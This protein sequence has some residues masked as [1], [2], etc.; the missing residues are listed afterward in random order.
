MLDML[1]MTRPKTAL[2]E[3][4]AN[5]GAPAAETDGKGQMKML[6]LGSLSLLFSLTCGCRGEEIRHC[7]ASSSCLKYSD[8]G[9]V[10]A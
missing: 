2:A 8:P 1:R 4:N 7:R 5:M 3:A 9:V 10:C 6:M